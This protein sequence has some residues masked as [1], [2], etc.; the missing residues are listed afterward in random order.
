MK[1]KRIII[2]ISPE[3]HMKFKT[4]AVKHEKTMS[5]FIREIIDSI[6]DKEDIK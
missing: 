3:K 5:N 4:Y 2:E 6:L 1:N